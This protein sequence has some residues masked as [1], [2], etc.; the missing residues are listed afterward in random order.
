MNSNREQWSKDHLFQRRPVISGLGATRLLNADE[1]G[2][3]TLLD[4][5]DGIVIT[6]PTYAS[7]GKPGMYFDF[8]V[9]ATLTSGAYKIITGAATELLVG[10]VINCDTDSSDAV[11]IWKSL[12]ATSNISVNFNGTTK[13]GVKGDTLRFTNLDATTWQVSGVTNGNGVVVTPFATS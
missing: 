12:V 4:K 10:S 11:A 2:S 6:L 3:V 7:I 13:G 9:S 5:V 1:S 8:I